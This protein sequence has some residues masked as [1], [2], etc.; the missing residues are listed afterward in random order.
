MLVVVGVVYMAFSAYLVKDDMAHAVRWALGRRQG[1][2]KSEVEAT[3]QLQ[4]PL[5]GDLEQP[6]ADEPARR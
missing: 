3:M 6:Q 5:L 2:D 4:E 1:G